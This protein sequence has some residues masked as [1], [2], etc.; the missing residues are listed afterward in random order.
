MNH[1]NQEKI[2]AIEQID[3]IYK[4]IQE[5]FNINIYGPEIAFNGLAIA[6]IP[7][8]E[9]L[10]STTIDP[11][12]ASILP[13]KT[14]IL[15]IIRSIFYWVLF[16]G[17]SRYF[18]P[19]EKLYPEN[20]LIRKVIEQ[21]N[22]FA[23]IPIATAMALIFSGQEI[24]IAPIIC[25]ILGSQL[26]QISKFTKSII[27]I[28]AW[29]QILIGII[30]IILTKYAILNLWGYIIALFGTTLIVAGLILTKNQNK[31]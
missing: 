25:I 7:L 22:F 13:Y 11:F 16:Y 12:F 30:G 24:F 29:A 5:N 17:I 14:A 3:T 2:N 1:N 26:L 15:F 10:F 20:K 31:F 21:N 28:T 18:E 9:S 6:C 19:K 4:T 8:I 27:K 23:I